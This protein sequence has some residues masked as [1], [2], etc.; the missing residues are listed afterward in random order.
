MAKTTPRQFRF[1]DEDLAL[2]DRLAEVLAPELGF[3]RTRVS[4]LRFA[5]REL[6]A[7]RMPK[8]PRKNPGKSEKS[9]E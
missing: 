7:R 5:L 2:M 6:A 4:V 1:T 9:R 8:G 3:V